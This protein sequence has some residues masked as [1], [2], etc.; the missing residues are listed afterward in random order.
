[1]V[2]LTESSHSERSR[3]GNTFSCQSDDTGYVDRKYH[4]LA[5]N[6]TREGTICTTEIA[7]FVQGDDGRSIDSHDP[8]DEDGKDGGEG[9]HSDRLRLLKYRIRRGEKI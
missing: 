2:I 6:C 8:G 9:A 7:A 5:G 3:T 4:Y 1:M